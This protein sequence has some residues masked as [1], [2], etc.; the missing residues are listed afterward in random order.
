MALFHARSSRTIALGLSGAAVFAFAAAALVRRARALHLRGKVAIVTGGSRGLGLRIAVELGR[1]GAT[2]AICGRDE[3]AVLRA[4]RALAGCGI[5]VLSV[6][7]DLGD[8][9]A[10]QSFVERVAREYGRID[11]LVNNAGVMQVAPLAQVDVG[12]IDEAMRANFWSAVHTT[13]AA[14]PF[15]EKSASGG[16]IVNIASVGG[17]VALPHMLGYTA[18][19]FAMTGFSEA[20]RPECSARGVRVTTVSPGPM[21]TGSFYN[22]EFL[23]HQRQEFAWFS[24]LSS[25]PLL[26]T[27]A[28]RAAKRIVQA[29]RE[30]R[31]ELRIG[32]AGY[33]LP[34]IHGLFPKLFARLTTAVARALPGPSSSDERW[35]GR[36]INS[37][38]PGSW[39]LGL[40]DQAARANNEEPPA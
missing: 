19:K 28:E 25:L 40:G 33:L 7:C 27:S 36:E 8:P 4:G 10:A 15:L 37:T 26:S 29:A 16:R 21:R 9:A 3:A 17:R 20:L 30:G 39:L 32:L 22:A 31:S 35:K 13:Y 12:M 11:L 38:L 18:S 14:L 5:E 34:L 2:V 24:L 1:K 23:G 6:A